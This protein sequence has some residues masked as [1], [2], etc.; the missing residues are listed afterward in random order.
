L[1]TSRTYLTVLE[2]NGCFLF[3]GEISRQDNFNQRQSWKSTNHTGLW[4]LWWMFTEIWVYNSLAILYR[5]IWLFK[6]I[7]NNWWQ[8]RFC[9]IALLLAHLSYCHRYTSVVFVYEIWTSVKTFWN[10]S[11]RDVVMVPN[12]ETHLIMEYML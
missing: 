7:C 3:S 12:N 6:F 11:S 9:Y 1:E 5:N 2:Y 4:F 10:R 8:G